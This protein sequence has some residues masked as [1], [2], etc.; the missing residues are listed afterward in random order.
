MLKKTWTVTLLAGLVSAAFI[1]GAA[2]QDG[3]AYAP[4]AQ[5]QAAPQPAQSQPPA[6]QPQQF[7][8]IRLELN[9]FVT[10]QKGNSLA[11]TKSVLM[12]A[13]DR[14]NARVRTGRS[15]STTPQPANMAIELGPVLNVDATPE[16]LS[17]GRL[18]VSLSFEYRPDASADKMEPIHIN[19]RLSAVLED[20]KPMV[21]SQT[22]D[23]AGDRNVKVELK[24]SILR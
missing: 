10:D 18:R 20:G 22:S 13:V 6:R 16:I 4:A 3:V 8:N 14:D 12:H 9:I 15:A 7:V 11:P 21:V 24:A 1:T 17:N 19:E 5:A 2:A 23:P